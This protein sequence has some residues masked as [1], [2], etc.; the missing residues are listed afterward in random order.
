MCERD[1]INAYSD[2]AI[3]VKRRSQVIEHIPERL[4]K[5]ITPM[6]EDGRLK[7]IDGCISGPKWPVPKSES[8]FATPPVKRKLSETDL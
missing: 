4:A 8:V 1:H 3:V 6:L 2:I 5:I 7:K